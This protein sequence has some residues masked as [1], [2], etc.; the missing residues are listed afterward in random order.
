MTRR[1]PILTFADIAKRY[2]PTEVLRKVDLGVVPGEFMVV[3]GSPTSGKSV[4]M[5]L[6]MGLEPPTAGRITLRGEEI[7]RLPAAERN[8]GYVPQSFAL[9]PHLSVHDNIAYP[10]KLAGVGARAGAP[11]VHRAAEMLKIADLLAKRPDQLSGGQKQR[12]AIARGIAKQTDVFV[13]DDPLAGLD[14]KL[15]EQLVGDLRDLQ[16]ETG[17]TFVYTT[18]DALEALTLAD[19]IAVLAG[20]RIVE[21]GQP[22]RLYD[23]P[24]RVETMRLLG[25]PQANLLT[26]RLVARDG[27]LWCETAPLAFP[28]RLIDGAGAAP[29]GEPVRV[30][31]RP[32]AIAFAGHAA[33]NGQLRLPAR[34]LLREDLG[35]EEIIYLDVAGTALT[36]VV[37]HDTDT[38][39]AADAATV[40]LDPATIL[41]YSPVG[42]WI[43]RGVGSD[44]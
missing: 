41:L 1:E 25:F 29:D 35:G 10:L 12:V 31:I 26:G 22:E 24:T 15:R 13:L 39:L 5:R 16:V 33:A 9:Y 37:R 43:G 38:D 20:G 2:G 21:V 4:L 6:L 42:E 7:T 11:I 23:T 17:A 28:V 30:G 44:V 18:S 14:F 40:A 3:F 36:T 19:R 8:I 32:E 27:G 34:V